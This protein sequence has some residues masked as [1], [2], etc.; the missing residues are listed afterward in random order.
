M[1]L[2][3]VISAFAALI[4]GLAVVAPSPA[5]EWLL[6]DN[7]CDFC[8]KYSSSAKVAR[9]CSSCARGSNNCDFCGKYSS[10][11]K[12]ARVC[13]SCARG[14]NNCDFCGK[15]SSSAKVAHVCNSCKR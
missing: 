13:S 11:A 3:T 1:R 7:N 10:S 6:G 15:Y 12:V 2:A 14:S 8:G 4:V 9:V 5:N